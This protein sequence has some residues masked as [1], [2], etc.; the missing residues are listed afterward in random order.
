MG[1]LSLKIEHVEPDG[2]ATALNWVYQ[3]LPQPD[4]SRLV[5]EL[6]EG[7]S[8][9]TTDLSGLLAAHRGS[10]LVGAVWAQPLPGRTAVIWPPDAAP[11][12]GLATHMALLQAAV[13][14]LN[15]LD[16]GMAQVLLDMSDE[17]AQVPLEQTG[18]IHLANLLYM[19]S[20]DTEFPQLRPNSPLRFEPVESGSW[21]RFRRVVEATYVDTLDCPPLS[22]ARQ[23]D[24]VLDGYRAAGQ[25]GQTGWWIVTE[26]DRDTGCLIMADH[27][28]QKQRELVYMGL[29]P[30]ARGH[31]HGLSIVQFA[32]WQVRLA[33]Y[34]RLV[35]AVDAA[36]KPALAIYEAAGCIVWDRKRVY[37]RRFPDK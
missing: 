17:A 9:R 1:K 30:Q 16:V 20:L 33:G 12:E 6:L 3:H 27:P 15:G 22:G 14:F 24:D 2:Q 8:A 32:Q 5:D 28:E 13:E 23:I 36:N 4:R 31:G 19:I 25:I 37:W 21:Q 7:R 10:E 34:R 11:G 18:F 26:N 29:V 35:L